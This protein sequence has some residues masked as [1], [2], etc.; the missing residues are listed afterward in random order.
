MGEQLMHEE[1]LL[2]LGMALIT[3]TIRYLPLA[4][5]EQMELPPA[6]VKALRYV[7]PTVL[8]AIVVPEV[9]IPGGEW[10]PAATWPRWLGALV[11]LGISWRTQ[12]LLL[13]ILL[14]MAVFFLARVLG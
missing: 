1:W 6:L 9:L 13:T 7:P 4:L 3:F 8:T 12:N 11:A 10:D 2:I 5:G 14:G